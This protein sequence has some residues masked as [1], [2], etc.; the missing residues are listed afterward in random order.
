[1]NI[2]RRRFLAGLETPWISEQ[3]RHLEEVRLRA[4]ECWAAAGLGIGGGELADAEVAAAKLVAESPLRETGYLLLMGVLDA[5]GNPAEAVRVYERLR[6]TLRDELGLTP[7][8]R[9][10]D[11]HAR[12]LLRGEDQA[13]ARP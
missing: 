9:A 1:M 4:L 7:G 2:S 6:T 11:L 10:R 12:L 3:R 13:S 8:P 5:R